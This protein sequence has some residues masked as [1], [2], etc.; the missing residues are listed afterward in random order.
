M[1]T[2]ETLKGNFLNIYRQVWLAA[3]GAIATVGQESKQIADKVSKWDIKQSAKDFEKS[4]RDI[5]SD[6]QEKMGTILTKMSIPKFA[7]N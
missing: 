5:F 2:V 4:Y 1:I 6:V 7:M 3:L